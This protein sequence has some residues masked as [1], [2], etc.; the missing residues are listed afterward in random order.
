MTS[1]SRMAQTPP[2][3]SGTR[4]GELRQQRSQGFLYLSIP[5]VGE[6]TALVLANYYLGS[7]VL[8]LFLEDQNREV[9]RALFSPSVR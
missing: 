9:T 4:S 3:N 5:N 8:A 7:R 2:T 1:I 6:A